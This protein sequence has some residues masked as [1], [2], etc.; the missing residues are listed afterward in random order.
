MDFWLRQDVDPST[1]LSK[2]ISNEELEIV[3]DRGRALQAGKRICD[4]VEGQLLSGVEKEKNSTLSPI[5][6]SSNSAMLPVLQPDIPSNSEASVG[7][8]RMRENVDNTELQ[9][10]TSSSYL[11][12]RISESVSSSSSTTVFDAQAKARSDQKKWTDLASMALFTPLSGAG[13]EFKYTAAG[14]GL[15]TSVNASTFVGRPEATDVDDDKKEVS[16]S[17]VQNK[18]HSS[19]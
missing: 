5:T 8:K 18:E 13:Y 7:V 1:S 14:R 9:S 15:L 17:K 10:S 3:L 11:L 16:L 19:A 12:S 4:D 6:V 2:G